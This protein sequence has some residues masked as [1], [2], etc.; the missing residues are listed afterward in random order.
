[1]TSIVHLVGFGC[2]IKRLL[3]VASLFYVYIWSCKSIT[4]TMYRESV[5]K[6]NP[7]RLSVKSHDIL[8]DA[9]RKRFQIVLLKP[10]MAT[11][12]WRKTMALRVKVM[13]TRILR[14]S[15]GEYAHVSKYQII[16]V[17]G[18]CVG[19]FCSSVKNE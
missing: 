4:Q 16:V 1:M 7:M 12:I 8:M 6:L 14:M 9:A 19:E 10:V 18:I 17:S 11:K 3:S 15:E 13:N 5:L 2:Q